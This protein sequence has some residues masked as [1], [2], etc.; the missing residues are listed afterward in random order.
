MAEILLMRRKTRNNHSIYQTNILL[1]QEFIYYLFVLVVLP[2]GKE[3]SVVDIEQ[4]VLF[5][6]GMV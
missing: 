6:D 2:K 4:I 5:V 3:G 1:H